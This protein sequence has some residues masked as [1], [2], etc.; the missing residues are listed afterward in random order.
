MLPTDCQLFQNFLDAIVDVHSIRHVTFRNEQ[1]CPCD[2][3]HLRNTYTLELGK[4]NRR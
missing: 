4:K 3:I 2:F 1:I